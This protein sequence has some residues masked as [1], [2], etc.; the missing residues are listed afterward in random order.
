MDADRYVEAFRLNLSLPPNVTAFIG[1]IRFDEGTEA[2]EGWRA[3]YG[4]RKGRDDRLFTDTSVHPR[5]RFWILTGEEVVPG[6]S[7]GP[8]DTTTAA[9]AGQFNWPTWSDHMAA[10]GPMPFDQAGQT[11]CFVWLFQSRAR[12]YDDV[13]AGR[14]EIACAKCAPIWASLPQSLAG[15]HPKSMDATRTA[16]LNCGGQIA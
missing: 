13:V 8:S 7:F 16:Y 12:C 11:R 2:P 5:R 9:G 15:Q 4:W 6:E 3:L 1:A 14:F 10:N